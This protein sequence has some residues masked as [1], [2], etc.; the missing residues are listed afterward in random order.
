MEP[1]VRHGA[2]ATGPK[3][4]HAPVRRDANHFRAARR[5]SGFVRFF[6]WALPA[7]V[8]LVLG[9]ILAANYLNPFRLGVDLPFDLGRVSMSGTRVMMELPRLHG[10]TSDNRGYD[11]SAE[12]AT[13]DLT[14]P[15]QIDLNTIKAK[16]ELA[17]KGWAK[18]TASTGRYD[19]KTE[20]LQ[21][22]G[23]VHFDTSAG[24]AGTLKEASIDVKDGRMVSDHPVELTYVDGKLT[25]DRME[26]TQKDS[27]ALLT[28]HVQLNFRLPPPDDGKASKNGKGADK[29]GAPG[30]QGSAAPRLRGADAGQVP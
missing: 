3:A 8:L 13:Q 19:T 27:R 11:V 29:G 14:Q 21:L 30:G 20:Q 23:G 1:P 2:A 25:A 22:G 10:F 6:R 17:D 15:D 9:A 28:G 4:R 24:Y 7:G 18:L 16:L 5:H 12:S 26:V